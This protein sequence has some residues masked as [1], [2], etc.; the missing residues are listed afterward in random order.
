MRLARTGLLL[1]LLATPGAA[2]W[3]ASLV[4]A[5]SGASLR[6]SLLLAGALDA[7]AA[8]GVFGAPTVD[9][10]VFDAPV[11][12]RMCPDQAGQPQGEANCAGAEVTN[13]ARLY[14]HAGGAIVRVDAAAPI[15][16]RGPATVAALGG[17]NVTLNTFDVG[18]GVYSGGATTVTSN[19]TVYALRPLQSQA[20]LELRGNE[21]FRTYNGTAYT[22]YL[23]NAS[24]ATLSAR[25]AFLGGPG[26]EATL[27]RAPLAA[28]EDAIRIEDLYTLLH[29]V[30]PPTTADRRADLAEAFG[31]FALV[32]ALLDGGAAARTNLTLN[33]AARGE[34]TFLHVSDLRMGSDGVLWTGSGN[35]SY[36]VDNDVVTPELGESVRFPIALPILLLAAALLARLVTHREPAPKRRRL[37]AHA[38]R[39]A[40]LVALTFLAAAALAPLFGFS[41]LLDA[42]VLTFRSRVQLALLVVGMVACA[43]LAVGLPGESLARS[44]LSWRAQPRAAVVP[45]VVGLLAALLFVLLAAP[46]LLSFV[47]RFVR[48]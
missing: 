23:R 21:G 5:P 25:G 12:A 2:A 4:S 28:A 29:A 24:V 38:L 6:E 34:F 32:P 44:A 43:W 18:T 45:V 48:L 15:A 39:I 7:S 17:P 47:V 46:V 27:A 30:Q 9:T 41:P 31:P 10:L 8:G 22:L 19:S 40:G 11:R 35:V 20:S 26:P 36:A 33:G 14:F 16:L 37:L 3:P 13:D 42:R 1:L